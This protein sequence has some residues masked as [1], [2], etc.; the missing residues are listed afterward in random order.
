MEWLPLGL[1]DILL[2]LV[3]VAAI[4]L[5]FVLF[6]LIQIGRRRLPRETAIEPEE[7]LAGEEPYRATAAPYLSMEPEVTSVGDAPQPTAVAAPPTV[8]R[9]ALAAYEDA[10]APEEHFVAPPSPNFEWD[11]VK[12]LFG[13]AEAPATTSP[14][15]SPS[16]LPRSSGFGEPIADHLARTDMEMEIQRM[17]DE[18]LQMRQELE[19]LRAARRVSPQY[20]EAMEL[21]QRG[22]SAQDVADRLGISL[23]E[24][25][26]V[27][28]LSRGRQNF[29]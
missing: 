25:E 2:L 4:Y 24:A 12:D 19:E 3:V 7:P 15:P 17:R 29:D 21:V 13:E 27:Q 9:Q 20:A 6:R 8:A 26:L 23:G 14:L 5:V 16:A 18:M 22:L 10:A 1:R 28:A 11:E